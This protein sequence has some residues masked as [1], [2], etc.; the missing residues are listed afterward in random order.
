[1]LASRSIPACAG[2]PGRGTAATGPEGVYPRVCG[3]TRTPHTR[4]GRRS[5]LSPRVRGNLP[6]VHVRPVGVG[7][8]PACAGEPFRRPFPWP[9]RRVYPR[10][11]G[12]TCSWLATRSRRLGLSPRVRGNPRA[13]R[14]DQAVKGSIPACAGEPRSA[15]RQC[16]RSRVYPRVCGGTVPGVP[17]SPSTPGL[18]PRVRGN[19]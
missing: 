2:E 12:G 1:M 4:T 17:S 14:V 9:R 16:Q 15:G 19:P 7:S 5:G 8:I 18:S 6:V 11:C 10:V 3:G 13:A